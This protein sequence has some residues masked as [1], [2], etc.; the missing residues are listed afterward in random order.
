[1]R[2]LIN[3]ASAHMGGAV[4]YLRNVLHWLPVIAPEHHVVVYVPEATATRMAQMATTTMNSTT[5]IARL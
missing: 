1:M 5:V 4:T 3:A 2:I